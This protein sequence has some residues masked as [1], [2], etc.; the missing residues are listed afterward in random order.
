[1]KNYKRYFLYNIVFLL[2]EIKFMLF[3]LRTLDL[4]DEYKMK[5][6]KI[7]NEVNDL[8]LNLNEKLDLSQ[9]DQVFQGDEK[10]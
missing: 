2:S 9:F 10:K 1:M 7:E 8:M 6:N 5:L 3:H 4:T